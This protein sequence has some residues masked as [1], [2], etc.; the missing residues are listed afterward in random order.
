[1][2]IKVIQFLVHIIEKSEK[3]TVYNKSSHDKLETYELL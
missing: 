2:K 3:E 1:M